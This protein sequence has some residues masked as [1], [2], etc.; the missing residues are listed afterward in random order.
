MTNPNDTTPA[1]TAAEL[2]IPIGNEKWTQVLPVL[3]AAIE[4]GTP[5]GVRMAKDHLAQMA[6]VADLAATALGTLML[7][8]A[9]GKPLDADVANALSLSK[10]DT[11][12]RGH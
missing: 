4:S 8:A 9:N 7:Q 11:S 12:S 6:A 1:A 3:L 10:L 2:S 5:A